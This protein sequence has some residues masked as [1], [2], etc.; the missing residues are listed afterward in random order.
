MFRVRNL[1]LIFVLLAS[2]HASAATHGEYGQAIERQLRQHL[3]VPDGPATQFVSFDFPD[4]GV[5]VVL[6]T[7]LAMGNARRT[8]FVNQQQPKGRPGDA[9]ILN[10]MKQALLACASLHRN[11]GSLHLVIVDRALFSNPFE[12]SRSPVLYKAWVSFTDLR[13]SDADSLIRAEA[14]K[15]R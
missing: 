3:S 5:F 7:D 10:A 1:V 11:A 8:P 13:A 12:D 2:Y 9:A 14:P 4:G 15:T 6:T